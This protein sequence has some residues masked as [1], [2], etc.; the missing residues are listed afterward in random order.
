MSPCIEPPELS[1]ARLW[2]YHDGRAGMDVKKHLERC[3]YC[4]ARANR[5]ADFHNRLAAKLYRLDCP[6]STN[7]GEYQ[8]GLLSGTKEEVIRRH[9]GECPHCSAEITQLKNYLGQLAPETDISFVESIKVFVARLIPPNTLLSQ[10]GSSSLA[11]A[12]YGL[13]GEQIGPQLYEAG[14]YQVSLEAQ[15]D[16][17]STGHR[18]LL[19]L[20]TGIGPGSWHAQLTP[21]EG[22][23]LSEPVDALGNFVISA[24]SV[25]LYQLLLVGPT[26]EIYIQNLV[27]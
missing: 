6:S 14:S 13:R 1:D 25:G 16:P 21:E 12:A 17:A 27:I 24:L 22:P 20:V 9:L 26:T 2:E 3:I 11:S 8:L 15:N 23:V 4:R 5:L 19:G 7:L 18:I 10:T